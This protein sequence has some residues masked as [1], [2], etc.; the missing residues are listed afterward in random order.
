MLAKQSWEFVPVDACQDWNLATDDVL[1]WLWLLG[2]CW[3]GVHQGVEAR[4]SVF[5]W[6][7]NLELDT[8]LQYITCFLKTLLIGGSLFP[9]KQIH[10]TTWTSPD[11]VTHNQIDHI[12]INKKCLSLGQ[13]RHCQQLHPHDWHHLPLTAQNAKEKD[14]TTAVRL[15]QTKEPANQAACHNAGMEQV[16][17]SRGW[18]RDHSRYFKPDF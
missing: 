10:K 15:R 14:K 17:S 5:H 13:S 16:S 18:I 2:L 12:T 9:R 7:F 4:W 6:T 1:A 11:R 8:G 3:L